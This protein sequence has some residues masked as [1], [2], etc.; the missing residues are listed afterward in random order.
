V[1]RDTFFIVSRALLLLSLFLFFTEVSGLRELLT[2]AC[3]EQ[4]ADDDENG[5]CAADCTDCTC[6]AHPRA[7]SASPQIVARPHVSFERTADVRSLIYW[8]ESDGISHVPRAI[9]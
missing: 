2:F 9:A 5:N 3:I 1:S 8:T 7:A 6:C 4:C